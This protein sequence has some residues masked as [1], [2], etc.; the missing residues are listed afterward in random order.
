MK[1]P[2][3]LT[4]RKM[5][6]IL[7]LHFELKL[8]QAQTAKSLNISKGVVCKYVN[9]AKA[10]GINWP[11]PDGMTDQKLAN[12]FKISQDNLETIDF[13]EIHTDK[14]RKAVTLMLLWEEYVETSN[15]NISYSQF[16]RRYKSWLKTQP[17]SMRQFHKAGE[18]I[19][20]DYSGMTMNI[21]DPET[22][23][24]R[25]AEIFVGVLGLSLYTYAEATWT[26]QLSDW[27]ASNVRM[28]EFFGGAAQ[29][30]VPDNLKSAV[31]KADKYD[32]DINPAYYDMASHYSTAI[33]PAR[34][35]KPKDKSKA[36]GAVCLVQRW[37][38][39]RLRKQTF[40]GLDELNS[41]IQELL[42]TLNNRGFKKKDGSRKSWFEQYE[43][44][45]LQVLPQL[46]YVYRIY[47]KAKVNI[48]YHIQLGNHCYSVP[49]KYIGKHIDV[50]Y[51]NTTVSCYYQSELI[52]EHIRMTKYGLTTI[53]LHMP[54]SHAN[55]KKN[56]SREGIM[57]R[58]QNI[59]DSTAQLIERV[60]D[61]KPHE[62]Q[63]YRTC[64]GILSL[65]KQY[66]HE[67]IELACEYA[68]GHN[69]STRKN[70]KNIIA[71][72]IART[73]SIQPDYVSIDHS[74]IR[75]SYYY[76]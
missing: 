46:R 56:N 39:A 23:E 76:H 59:G 37:I 8:T 55:H 16:C 18:K 72:D 71:N 5:K 4:I 64:L 34:P 44:S 38:L 10:L 58:A 33:M 21:I 45:E 73:A 57:Y 24:V 61:S 75:G 40:V 19:F 47:K 28:F 42:I 43:K 15:N 14:Q 50:W 66:T 1:K 27:I 12:C 52:A 41:A 35:Y 29:I 54:K 67:D 32:P 11:L 20:V 13:S 22:F 9:R 69:I 25:S 70:I 65:G 49:F 17:K 53:D 68:L 2:T 3:G 31:T 48:D 51:N 30:L 60:L 62:E 63:A 6:E 26:Q 74:N 36:E 7:R